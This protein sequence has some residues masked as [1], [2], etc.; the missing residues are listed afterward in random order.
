MIEVSNASVLVIDDEE[1]VRDN[2]EEILSPARSNLETD[3]MVR[4]AGI[5]FDTA[6]KP[7]NG[8]G[9]A[10]ASRHRA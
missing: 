5:L 9:V 6:T 7:V 8:S 4:A 3:S 10:G 2:I 1:M